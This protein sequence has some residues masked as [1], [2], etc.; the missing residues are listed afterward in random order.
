MDKLAKS[1]KRVPRYQGKQ[2]SGEVFPFF[3]LLFIAS[4]GPSSVVLLAAH[5]LRGEVEPGAERGVGQ[6]VRFSIHIVR[7]PRQKYVV[8]VAGRRKLE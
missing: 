6:S 3:G 5:N 8:Y 4:L 1:V 7:G 2:G